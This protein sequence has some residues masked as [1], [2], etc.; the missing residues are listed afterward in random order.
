MVT[1]D[2]RIDKI[3]ESIIKCC[4]STIPD[5]DKEFYVRQE[6]KNMYNIGLEKVFDNSHS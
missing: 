5:K 3:V 2:K 6:I 1:I 4:N